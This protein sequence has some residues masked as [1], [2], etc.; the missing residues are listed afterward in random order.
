MKLI[1]LFLSFCVGNLVSGQI[2]RY[3][4]PCNVGQRVCE[5]REDADECEFTLVIEELQTF[6]SYEIKTVQP[7]SFA[8][9]ALGRGTP[10]YRLEDGAPYYLNASGY[11]QPV[12]DADEPDEVI[13][14]QTYNENFASLQCTVPQTVDGKTY[15]PYIG[16][17][18]LVPGPT[19]IVNE[20]QNMIVNVNNRLIS[21]T[22]SIHWHGM[23]MRNT[24]W[25]DGALLV[26]QCPISPGETFRYY[27]QAAPTG[28]FWYHS[29]R[30]TQRMDGLF[31]AL[32][33]K[34]SP[35]RLQNLQNRVGSF[36]DAPDKYTID[37]HEWNRETMLDLY[38]NIVGE[39][40]F[41]PN[42]PIGDIPLPEIVPRI[43]GMIDPNEDWDEEESSGPDGLTNGDLPFWSALI[44]GRGRHYSVP[45]NQSRLEIFSVDEG[46]SYRFRL[47]GSQGLYGLRFSIDEH[48]L[49]VISTDGSLI[50]P[51]STQF[52]ILHTGERYDFIL[53][54]NR[55]RSNVS[56]Y[57][58][59]VE[60]LEVDLD[61][62]G[63][64]YPSRGNMAEA[65]L[66]YSTTSN[67]ATPIPVPR[68]TDYEQIKTTSIPFSVMRCRDIGGCTAV[69]CP[70]EA[71]HTSYNIRCVNALEFRMLEDI[72]NNSLPDPNPD[73]NCGD[74]E[75]FFNIGSVENTINGRNMVLP[76]SPLQTQKSDIFPSDFCNVNQPCDGDSCDCVHVRDITT[77]NGT[78]RFV[79]SSIGDEVSEGEGF[80]HPI[81][82]HGHHFQVVGMGYA[83]YNQSNG[84][85]LSQR[86]DLVC[87][88]S[89]CSSPRWSESSPLYPANSKA[90]LK[91]TIMVPA[92]GYAVI[93]FR[94]DN[95]GFWFMHCHIVPDLLEGMAV[96]INEVEK[97]QNP[98]PEG[99][100]VCG[101]YRIA[102]SVFYEKLAFDPD[103][104]NMKLS[105][106]V[107]SILLLCLF[108]LFVF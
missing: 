95:P 98:P 6:V 24:P 41:F 10:G 71:Y 47:I 104:S 54:A 102:Q 32:I 56:D 25:M 55:P 90:V 21:E 42:K 50:E 30:V 96:V 69:N 17:N 93:Q 107:A 100:K 48:N 44:N 76:V 51:I 67:S 79:L 37:L 29:H 105:A 2:D 85:L 36:I 78:I 82:L 26:S 52:I 39:L 72:P 45:Y 33:V 97:R 73:P 83:T 70:F 64:P 40:P 14:C 13:P 19:L 34:E 35:E 8:S 57:W 61:A 66:H 75:L 12:G 87:D 63:P 60:T 1:V 38:N 80:T 99:T 53:T 23:D 77:F 43:P 7:V 4:V 68:S 86:E 84:Y 103:S 9:D 28:S 16:V 65:I 92:G 5:C 106:S 3:V 15:R 11:L 58:I 20:G 81:H 49:T 31:G 22:T 74:C 101:D 89:L 91:D 108:S 94:S 46:N 88:D 59:R 18:G 27:F 62:P